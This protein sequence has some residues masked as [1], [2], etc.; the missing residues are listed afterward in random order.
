[1]KTKM[2]QIIERHKM[3]DDLKLLRQM[4]GMVNSP[5]LDL[6]ELAANSGLPAAGKAMETAATICFKETMA[7][8]LMPPVPVKRIPPA[9]QPYVVIG[10]DPITGEY[11][12]L[13][14]S[15]LCRGLGI[16]GSCGS[17]KTVTLFN[18]LSGIGNDVFLYAPD[19]KHEVWRIF[20]KL[21][22][23]L[24]Y[25]RPNELYVNALEC[26]SPDVD[27]VAY[28]TGLMDVWSRPLDIDDA[29]WPEV[30]SLLIEVRTALPKD[31]PMLSLGEFPAL[32]KAAAERRKKSK[33][34]TAAAKFQVLAVGYGDA[35]WV[36]QGPD[37]RA[38]Y[39]G[40]G[41]NYA[42]VSHR[43][44]H[45]TDGRFLYAHMAICSAKGH[46]NDL[47]FLLCQRRREHVSRLAV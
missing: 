36:R 44:R 41:M 47:D 45:V 46:K 9:N 42:G 29:T 22:R 28:Y 5:H 14:H 24:L 6:L 37:L 35:A 10:V 39:S 3:V 40:L 2:E 30:A 8:Q 27:P 19:A 34:N 32:L 16:V 17:G 11:I 38:R 43:I 7:R 21:A 25:V 13:L 1:M 33:F 4:S 26:P 20:K 23:R 15:E 31:K 18:I 12:F